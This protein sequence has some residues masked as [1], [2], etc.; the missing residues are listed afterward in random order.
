[1]H[2]RHWFDDRRGI[3]SEWSQGLYHRKAKGSTRQSC[4]C[5]E[6]H[7]YIVRTIILLVYTQNHVYGTSISLSMDATDKSSISKARDFIAE[8]E[9]RLHVLVNKLVPN[10][11]CQ[12][13]LH[14]WYVTVLVKLAPSLDSW[15][16]TPHLNAK[17]LQRSVKLSSTTNHSTLGQ[18]YTRSTHSP[19]FSLL[20]LSL[21]CSIMG[22][23]KRRGTLLVLSTSPV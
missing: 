3:S 2:C 13:S 15:M 19:S 21:D 1:M 9:G 7:Y 11:K 17:M 6:W 16:I 8:K 18:I 22:Q 14:F 10:H 20:L 5:F 12:F 23:E 4:Q